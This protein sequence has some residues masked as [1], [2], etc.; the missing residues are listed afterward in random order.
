[1]DRPPKKEACQKAKKPK[2]EKTKPH[3]L[4]PAKVS[5]NNV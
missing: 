2:V 3:Q 5:I 1:M 4:S